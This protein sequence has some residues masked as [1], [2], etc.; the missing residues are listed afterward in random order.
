MNELAVW[1]LVN[2]V[3]YGLPLMLLVSFLGSLGVPF[4]ITPVII[5]IG[6]LSYE[7]F[8]DWRLAALACLLGA[9]L[10]DISEFFIGRWAGKWFRRRF[11]EKMDWE[12]ALEKFSRQGDWAIL[13]TRFWLMPLAPPINV[14]AGSQYS[15][16]RFLLVDFIGELIWVLVYGGLGYL[17]AGELERVIQVVE[18][19]GWFS[20]ALV[21]VGVGIYLIWHRGRPSKIIR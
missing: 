17:F 21:I 19:F 18:K 3:N 4:P 5:A 9:M 20:L 7:G 10:A 12:Q 11:G 6:A 2:L 13:L 16:W 14:I 1:A 15:F 8:F